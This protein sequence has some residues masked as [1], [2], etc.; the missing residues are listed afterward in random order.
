MSYVSLLDIE[1]IKREAKKIKKEFPCLPH[2]QCLDKASIKILKVRNYHEAS[3]LARKQIDSFVHH[4]GT[5]DKCS[6]CQL[7]FVATEKSDMKEHEIRHLE[8]EKVEHILGFIP[9]GM[10][11]REKEKRLAREELSI[12]NSDVIQM[13]G[14]LRLMRAYFE[15]SL[16]FSI[17]GRYWS[18]HPS[19]ER[20][21]AM[22]DLSHL[23]SKEIM[24]K[25]VKKYGRVE[26]EINK[27]MTYWSK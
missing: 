9:T 16:E 4:S 10:E 11:D 1:N 25:V 20:Y 3:K 21:I 13:N 17:I 24:D 2:G 22:L 6:Y 19:F 5:T 7:L 8:Y 27:G 18:K 14:A 23:F 26:G 12:N 15:R